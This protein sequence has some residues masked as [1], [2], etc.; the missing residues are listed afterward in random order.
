M[1][2]VF[3][4]I[5]YLLLF[6][7]VVAAAHGQATSESAPT[8]PELNLRLGHADLISGLAVSPDGRQLA[9]ASYDRTVRLWDLQS[10]AELGSLK[11]ATSVKAVTFLNNNQVVTG[12][13]DGTLLVWDLQSGHLQRSAKVGSSIDQ[14]FASPDGGQLWCTAQFTGV[15][16]LNASTLVVIAHYSNDLGVAVARTV[17]TDGAYCVVRWSG[18][19]GLVEWIA[20]RAVVEWWRG[21]VLVEAGK[22]YQVEK[23][24]TSAVVASDGLTLLLGTDNG[25]VHQLR[26]PKL[27]ERVSYAG[28][29]GAVVSVD[30]APDCINF[31]S[32]GRTDN[33]VLVR[34]V[35]TGSQIRKIVSPHGAPDRVLFTGT[36]DQFLVANGELNSARLL[37]ISTGQDLSFGRTATPV[38]KIQSSRDHRHLLTGTWYRAHLWDLATG[39][40]TNQFA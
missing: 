20:N 29:R 5:V 36:S 3:K 11:H 12:T 2:L 4:A 7:C 18:S 22:T 27:T 31:V 30:L 28:H 9:T 23:R 26:G 6:L 25:M 21:S 32:V 10:G 39:L 37:S 34:S 19:P 24:I 40:M 1:R 8:R 15:F 14:L 35:D 17:R 33:I 38:F 13:S 16:A